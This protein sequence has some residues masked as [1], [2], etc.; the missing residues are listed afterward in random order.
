MVTFT[1][2][3]LR[4][5]HVR[6]NRDENVSVNRK[7]QDLEDGVEG[8]QAG[9]VFGVALGQLV[10]D[11]DHG[12]ASGEADHDQAVHV[13]GIAAEEDDGQGEHQDRA[14]DPVLDKGQGKDLD[15][16]E[17]VAQLLVFHLGQ[18][19]IHHQDQ[20]DGDRDIG[21]AALELVDEPDDGRDK[22]S[23]SDPDGH[24]REDPESQIA[25]EK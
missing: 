22:I 18:R 19:G 14:D 20:S 6:K 24:G 16:A 10:P 1:A 21:R 7:E 12:D 15:V 3:P 9:R 11:D 23:Q 5:S 17:N 4:P 13:M 25:V 2:A 8:D